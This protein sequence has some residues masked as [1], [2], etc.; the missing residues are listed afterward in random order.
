M[1]AELHR[2]A[3]GRL[4][5]GIGQQADHDAVL[6]AVLFEL[7]VEIGV[8]EAA[9][10]PMFFDDYIFLLWCE[11]RMPFAAPCSFRKRLPLPGRNLIRIGMF[12]LLVV[13]GFSAM[14]RHDEE[15][16]FR[17]SRCRDDLAQMIEQMLFFGDLLDHRPKLCRRR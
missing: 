3:A 12:P 4:D 5:A 14:M 15:L 17:G 8:G 11:I 7:L 13:A 2:E 1:I 16:H 9:L 10:R 6:D